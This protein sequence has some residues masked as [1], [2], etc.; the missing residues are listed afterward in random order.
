MT[1]DTLTKY[2]RAHYGAM[3]GISLICVAAVIGSGFFAFQAEQ[4]ALAA[5]RQF[6]LMQ[7]EVQD[8]KEK[9]KNLDQMCSYQWDEG[10]DEATIDYEVVNPPYEDWGGC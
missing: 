10:Y 1:H 6:M 3:V 7:K 2:I 5:E 4:R 8:L 9:V